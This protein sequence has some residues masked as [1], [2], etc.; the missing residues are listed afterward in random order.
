MT[1]G[2]NP[3]VLWAAG[4]R[5]CSAA[6]ARRRRA[7][8]TRAIRPVLRPPPQ[9]PPRTRRRLAVPMAGGQARRIH[10]TRLIVR[11]SAWTVR[12]STALYSRP[13][14]SAGHRA[15]RDPE[16]TRTATCASNY[17][18]AQ[19]ELRSAARGYDERRPGLATGSSRRLPLPSIELP[20]ARILPRMA[21]H[22][23]SRPADSQGHRP[24]LPLGNRIRRAR[25]TFARA[26][27]RPL[28]TPTVAPPS[29]NSAPLSWHA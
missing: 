22:A 28:Q 20:R 3:R 16:G 15:D 11:V 21:G 18:E 25:P 9:E 13:A 27:S 10:R 24:A 26:G 1:M 8:K 17:P 6:S 23:S 7:L 14:L 5:N 29:V 12:R 4:S 19:A 2:M